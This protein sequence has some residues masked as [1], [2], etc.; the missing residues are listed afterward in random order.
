MS[1]NQTVPEYSIPSSK[2]ELEGVE[3][4]KDDVLGTLSL[5]E[6]VQVLERWVDEIGIDRTLL[7]SRCHYSGCCMIDAGK[8]FPRIHVKTSGEFDIVTL[9]CVVNHVFTQQHP[10]L[11][12]RRPGSAHLYIRIQPNDATIESALVYLESSDYYARVRLALLS[13]QSNVSV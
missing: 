5:E 4:L 8:E 13:K 2:E 10:T 11:F 12:L 6:I 7:T 1:N 9:C 3:T